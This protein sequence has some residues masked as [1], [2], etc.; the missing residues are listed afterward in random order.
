MT[1]SPLNI[2]A[3]TRSHSASSV[4]RDGRRILFLS[5]R[6]PEPAAPPPADFKSQAWLVWTN[7]VAQLDAAGMSVSN[8]AKVTTF[9]AQPEH[10]IENCEVRQEILGRHAPALAVIITEVFDERW[11]L[12]IEAIAVS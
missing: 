4:A 2:P 1:P 5:G 7:I 8:L 6:I 10:A 11:L 9:L 3:T 12:D